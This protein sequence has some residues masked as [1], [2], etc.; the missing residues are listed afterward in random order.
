MPSICL[1]QFRLPCME[2]TPPLQEDVEIVKSRLTLEK[3]DVCILLGDFR[4]RVSQE[5]TPTEEI[6]EI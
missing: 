5:L 3:E 1:P 2:S 6:A 4:Y